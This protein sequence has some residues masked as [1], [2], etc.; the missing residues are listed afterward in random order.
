MAEGRTITLEFLAAEYEIRQKLGQFARVLDG[1]AWA[2]LGEVFAEDV[3]FDYGSGI[4]ESGMDALR[5]NMRRFLDVCGPSQHLI[6]S[7]LIEVSA[8]GSTARSQS[9]VQARHQRP[10]DP[11]GPIFDCNGE[12]HDQWRRGPDGWR[13]MYRR[14]TWQS[15]FGDPAVLQAAEGDIH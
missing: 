7:L 12:Y 1:K 4:E 6:G 15:H 10:N 13:I 2:D 14:A 9:Y 5:A 11:L 3:R 8:D